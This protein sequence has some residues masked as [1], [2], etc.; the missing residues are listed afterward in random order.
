MYISTRMT[1]INDVIKKMTVTVQARC[2]EKIEEAAQ[3][4]KNGVN[5][6]KTEEYGVSSILKKKRGL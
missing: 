3:L 2:A 5:L 4:A 1:H 6:K